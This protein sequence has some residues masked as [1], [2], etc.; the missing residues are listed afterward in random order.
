M[1]DTKDEWHGQLAEAHPELYQFLDGVSALGD[2][3]NKYYLIYLAVRLAERTSASHTYCEKIW[4][5]GVQ[6]FEWRPST[7]GLFGY[8]EGIFRY[9]HSPTHRLRP[10]WGRS[11][12]E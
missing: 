8:K 4:W 9:P 2:K 6:F 3:S 11:A 7:T 12:L 1:A 10:Y 5:G